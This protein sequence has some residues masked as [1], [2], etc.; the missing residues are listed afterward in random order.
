MSDRLPDGF[1]D[2]PPTHHETVARASGSD[3]PFVGRGDHG[4][5]ERVPGDFFRALAT[6]YVQR[7]H[8]GKRPRRPLAVL[9]RERL[10]GTCQRV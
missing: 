2:T 10:N 7:V 3:A 8:R 9:L 1:P 6:L 4:S 5:L